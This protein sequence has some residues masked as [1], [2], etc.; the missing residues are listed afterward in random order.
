MALAGGCTLGWGGVYRTYP[1]VA[2]QP[3]PALRAVSQPAPVAM[4][5]IG[6]WLD[7]FFAKPWPYVQSIESGAAALLPVFQPPATRQPTV[8]FWP[9]AFW[10]LPW[11]YAQLQPSPVLAPPLL[12]PSAVPSYGWPSAFYRA[13]YP[14]VALIL[15]T[16]TLVAPFQPPPVAMPRAGLWP[17]RFWAGRWPYEQ[18]VPEPPQLAQVLAALSPLGPA[19]PDAFWRPL[20][21]IVQ[22]IGAGAPILLPVAQPPAVALPLI[23]PPP[24]AFWRLPWPYAQLQPSSPLLQPPTAALTPPALGW[25]LAFFRPP[26]P[27]VQLI[28]GGEPKRRPIVQPP[29]VAHPLLGRW[30]DA[31]WARPWP[32]RQLLLVHALI[33]LG[34]SL[35]LLIED[36]SA[37]RYLVYDSSRGWLYVFIDSSGA[38]Y[39][40]GNSSRARYDADDSSGPSTEVH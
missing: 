9:D 21:P 26:Y 6:E 3:P 11:P 19:L 15:A 23:G 13:P 25:P 35:P 16:P 31:F 2:V 18:F 12:A 34:V 7:A 37:V 10:R 22:L 24:S 1:Y 20:Y 4:P 5:K 36:S 30:P 14:T 40:V 33:P 8:G 29:P 32:Y 27:I 17:D 38:R 39:G 28:L